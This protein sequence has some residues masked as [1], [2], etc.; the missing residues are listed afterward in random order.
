MHPL[1][2]TRLA[3]ALVVAATLGCVALPGATT[4]AS[5]RGHRSFRSAS[6]QTAL[7]FTDSHHTSMCTA[8]G[9]TEKIPSSTGMTTFKVQV[10]EILPASAPSSTATAPA[11]QGTLNQDQR[12]DNSLTCAGYTASDANS[13]Q[14]FLGA[15][16]LGNVFYLVTD[17]VTN[18]KP[19]RAQFCLGALYPFTTR[20]G[21]SAGR[22]ILPNG[23]SGFVGLLPPCAP[24]QAGQLAS[25]APCVLT[26]TPSGNDA[27]LRVQVPAIGGDPWGRS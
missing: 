11:N 3:R 18:T 10:I 26:R 16:T 23:L 20:S 6:R 9:C 2:H 7:P 25:N 13:L 24:I 17:T 19:A 5:G 12:P 8:K 22:D 1:R 4:A 15:T 21:K 27:V 14:F